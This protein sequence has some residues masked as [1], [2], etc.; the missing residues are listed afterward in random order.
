MA[1]LE[2]YVPGYYLWN[3]MPSIPAAVIFIV[4]F[5]GATA[6]HVFKLFR[7][8]AWF[9]IPLAIGGIFEVIGYIARVDAHEHTAELVPY[10][11]QSVFILIAP[12]LFAASAYM[13]LGRII[14]SVNAEQHSLVPIRWLT[15]L[16]VTSDVVS[17]L[18]QGSGAGLMAMQSMRTL[19]KIIVIV[20]LVIQVIMFGF[21]IVASI[22]FYLRM[23]QRPTR[24]ALDK[25]QT[26]WK[27][28]IHTLFAV[29][30]LIMIRSIY[31][32]I[33]YAMG[34]NGYLL[35][36]EWPLYVFDTVLMW[37]VMVIWAVRYPGNIQ[38]GKPDMEL[39][40]TQDDGESI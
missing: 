6:V 21:F 28:H 13:V 24:K 10:S 12:V 17:F 26:L 38:M 39:K 7:S 11:I 20:G 5:L 40:T 1:K 19:A 36:N 27:H 3:Y 15:K 22:V 18:V 8:R 4:L 33:E 9:N 23:R 25:S 2:P 14:R 32:V 16:F 34:N 35:S 31:R 29:S 30:L 37:L